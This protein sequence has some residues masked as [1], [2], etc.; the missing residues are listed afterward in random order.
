MAKF[1]E[2]DALV[3]VAGY[4]GLRNAVVKE[5]GETHY[6][7]TIPCGIATVPISVEDNYRLD[8]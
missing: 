3:P 5:V 6:V 1:K 7:L 2:G 4:K 8:K